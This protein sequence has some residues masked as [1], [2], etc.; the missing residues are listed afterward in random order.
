MIDSHCHLDFEDYDLDR[1]NII[2]TAL[3]AGVFKIINPCSHYFSNFKVVE[4]SE[5]YNNYY[6]SI[7][8]H[9]E[10]VSKKNFGAPDNVNNPIGEIEK[11]ISNKKC[12][13]VG[14][15]GLDYY[16]INSDTGSCLNS[17]N[18][19]DIV[20]M[21]KKLFVSQLELA[22]K[23]NK[24]VIIHNR[25]SV[26]DIYNILKDYSLK[27]VIHCFSENLDW[28][29]KFIELGYYISFTGI[30]T[31]KNCGGNSLS[32]QIIHEPAIG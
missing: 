23:Y 10:E 16:Y 29:N 5:R 12:V 26:E 8:L 15:I 7:G 19:E 27:G 1:D 21:Q 2:K 6:F 31:F 30:I 24:P 20:K 11:I 25:E 14:E 28:A 22:S 4:L 9:P 13:A 17:I 32:S 3:D 18:V